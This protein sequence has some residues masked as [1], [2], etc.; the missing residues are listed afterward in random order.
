MS[1]SE[2][3]WRVIKATGEGLEARFTNGEVISA[4]LIRKLMLG[5]PVAVDTMP[6]P[7]PCGVRIIGAVIAGQVNLN[8]GRGRDGAVM[9]GLVL[10]RCIIADGIDVSYA[11][12]GKLSFE[13]SKLTALRGVRAVIEG[14]V[15]ANDIGPLHEGG[16]CFLSLH[17]VHIDGDI[18]LRR[19]CLRESEHY[20]V[21]NTEQFAVDLRNATINGSVFLRNI[22]CRGTIILSR[23]RVEGHVTFRSTRIAPR[24]GRRKTIIAKDC[25]IKGAITMRTF[26]QAPFLSLG[27]ITLA[28]SHVSAAVFD[29]AIITPEHID[30]TALDMHGV[31]VEGRLNFRNHFRT[32]GYT[33]LRGVEVGGDLGAGDAAFVLGLEAVGL[34]VGGDCTLNDVITNNAQIDLQD[35]RI[36]RVL[37]VTGV[38]ANLDLRRANTKTYDDNGECWRPYIIHLDGFVYERLERP[39]K[40]VGGAKAVNRQRQK[41]L[42]RQGDS[43]VY[44]K[45]VLKGGWHIVSGS[46]RLDVNKM[47]YRP[48]PFMQLS[49][50]LTAMG[51]ESDARQIMRAKEWIEARHVEK[52]LSRWVLKIFGGLF[53]FGYSSSR[54]F[55]TLLF[56]FII[57]WGGVWYLQ[58]ANL[59]ADDVQPVSTFAQTSGSNNAQLSQMIVP[60][61]NG[62]TT[63]ELTCSDIDSYSYALDLMI[64]LIDLHVETKCE[65][66][67]D[68]DEPD[69]YG[70]PIIR[71]GVKYFSQGVFNLPAHSFKPA[72]PHVT[73]IWR[74]AHTVYAMI[75]WLVVSLSILTFSGLLR[76][77]EHKA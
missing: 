24:P 27:E 12:L 57:G 64:P 46:P 72:W 34:T 65:V 25:V 54:A 35:A 53:G 16:D 39:G 19:A 32:T 60:I 45:G 56:Y 52:R 20:D 62:G 33:N 11:Q 22:D 44:R 37:K 51:M 71:A 63:K 49:R 26:D 38:M 59:L 42:S 6:V 15:I 36:G 74:L 13:G 30:G 18:Q 43:H 23:A 17:S 31:R 61:Y 68:S 2:A 69:I 41:W 3:E 55:C 50:A 58:D 73:Q 10:D 70:A 66:R 9:P 77:K 29:G 8:N 76:Q 75:G 5:L 21:F 40:R 4:D 14:E 7:T 67:R 48:Q 28:R 1:Y 47:D